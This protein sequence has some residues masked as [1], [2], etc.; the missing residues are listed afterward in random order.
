M[1]SDKENFVEHEGDKTY[2]KKPTFG[3]KLKRHCTRFWWVHLIV[4]IICVLV[5]TLPV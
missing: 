5:V 2:G 3:Q 1:A 4:L